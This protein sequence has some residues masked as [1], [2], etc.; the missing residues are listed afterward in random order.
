MRIKVRKIKTA[1]ASHPGR[2]CWWMSASACSPHEA[3][4][5]AL[6]KPNSRRNASFRCAFCE[7]EVHSGCVGR[8]PGP[9]E[10]GPL[11]RSHAWF[12]GKRAW[13]FLKTSG[14]SPSRVTRN[15]QLCRNLQQMLVTSH[16]STVSTLR[17]DDL[18]F[19][20]K[21]E[22]ACEETVN[23]VTS[24]WIGMEKR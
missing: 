10:T 13:R 2:V 22:R 11:R 15:R 17:Q 24:L 21:H 7:P 1:R 20:R 4:R 9:A 5:Y 3:G 23:A 14:N 18:C 6:T 8:R 12:P 16:A 19:K